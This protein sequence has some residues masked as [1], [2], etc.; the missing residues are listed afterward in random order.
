MDSEAR[1]P[2]GSGDIYGQCCRPFHQGAS[3][4][5]AEAL[6]R[7]RFC[8][9]AVGDEHYLLRTWDSSTRPSDIGLDPDL[10]WYRLDINHTTGGGPF[11][12]W[13]TV[14]FTAH[15]KPAP[16][17]DAPRGAQRENARFR[18]QNGT[19]FYV[20]GTLTSV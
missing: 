4:P 7:S 20:D 17:T 12:D 14:E 13:G 19:W 5:T 8:A 15:Y 16:N 9:F 3:A 6:M 11:E 2:C 18:R 10:R 1:C